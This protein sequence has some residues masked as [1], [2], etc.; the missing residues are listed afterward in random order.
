MTFN[1]RTFKH[2]NVIAKVVN[3]FG[4]DEHAVAHLSINKSVKVRR[5]TSQD[6]FRRF[7]CC[8]A[9]LFRFAALR[10]WTLCSERDTS[11]TRHDA[12]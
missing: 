10:F 6:K 3:H 2:F 9:F 1:L 7:V 5:L 12:R 4:G 11:L 8:G